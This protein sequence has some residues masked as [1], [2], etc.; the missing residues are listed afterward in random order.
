MK[1]LLILP[2]LAMGFALSAPAVEAAPP[3]QAV[4][5]G[6]SCAADNPE[7]GD[8]LTVVQFPE[9]GSA[10]HQWFDLS[11]DSGTRTLEAVVVNDNPLWSYQISVYEWDAVD[12]CAHQATQSF[13]RNIVRLGQLTRLIL[14]GEAPSLEDPLPAGQYRVRVS[15]GFS[16]G[17]GGKVGVLSIPGV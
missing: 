15:A 12:G 4:Q 13:G 2:A 11:F 17:A 1:R 8:P 9:D 5:D 10:L 16:Q 3:A 6:S 7:L 14:G